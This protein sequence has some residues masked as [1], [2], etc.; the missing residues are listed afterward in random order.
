MI[1]LFRHLGPKLVQRDKLST[2]YSP[3]WTLTLKCPVCGHET[4]IA[5]S[6]IAP[7]VHPV[8]SMKPHPV[9]IIERLKGDGSTEPERCWDDVTIEPSMKDLPHPRQVNCKAHFSVTRGHVI[10]G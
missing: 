9:E 6:G 1:S 5:V 2:P 4:S 3:V 8:W 10:P 7:A